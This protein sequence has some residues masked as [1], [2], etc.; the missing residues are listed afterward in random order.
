[1]AIKVEKYSAR[2]LEAVV[3]ILADAFVTNPLHVSAFGAH[4]LG[5]NRSFFRLGLRH[6]FRGEAL[7][8]LVNDQVCGYAHF[9]SSPNC[10]PAPEILPVAMGSLLKPYGKANVRLIP[11]F[12][13]WC[14]LDPDEPHLHLGPLGVAPQAQRQGIGT[15]LMRCY[16]ERLRR[17]GL[18]GYLETDKLENTSFYEKFGFVVQHEEELIGTPTWYMW[19]ERE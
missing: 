5:Q 8:A 4:Q 2:L 16:L 10:L 17:E 12:S 19:R 13:R 11:W 15:A 9:S 18:A 1:M 7:V 3:T 6:M 14:R